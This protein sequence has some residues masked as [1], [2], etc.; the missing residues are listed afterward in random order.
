MSFDQLVDEIKKLPR[1][2][3]EKLLD[4]V[5]EGFSESS[6]PEMDREHLEIIATRMATPGELIP[7]DEALKRARDLLNEL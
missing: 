7:G 6:D 4:R 3:Q 5:V 2:E 1:A